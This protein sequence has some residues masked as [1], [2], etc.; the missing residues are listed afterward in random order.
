MVTTG[1]SIQEAYQVITETGAKVVG[2]VTLVD[3][4]NVASGFFEREG[5]PY[6][7]LVTYRDLGI[8][9]VGDG[10]RHAEAV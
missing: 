1:G 8:A 10:H 9:P 4:G 3:R 2:A 6:V 7:P 5:I